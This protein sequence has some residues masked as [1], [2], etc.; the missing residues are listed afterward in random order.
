MQITAY[1][2]HNN[3]SLYYSISNMI[4]ETREG[5]EKG[6]TFHEESVETYLTG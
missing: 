4:L 2:K 3:I 1:F 5:S 6:H